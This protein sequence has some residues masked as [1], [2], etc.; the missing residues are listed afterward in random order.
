MLLVFNY[1]HELDDQMVSRDEDIIGFQNRTRRFPRCGIIWIRFF[2]WKNQRGKVVLTLAE[3]GMS[4]MLI[5]PAAEET[6]ERREFSS[7]FRYVLK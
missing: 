4:G 1:H 7:R 2:F 6:L 5:I 3:D